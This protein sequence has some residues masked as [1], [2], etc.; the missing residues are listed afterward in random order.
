[1]SYTHFSTDE[2][3]CLAQM[4][5]NGESQAKIARELGKNKSSISREIARNG[6]KDGT[7]QPWWAQSITIHRRRKQRRKILQ[8][9]EMKEYIEEK[10]KKYWSPETISAIWNRENPQRTISF[11]SIYRVLKEKK[12]DGVSVSKNLRRRGKRRYIRGAS[13]T[14]KPDKTI[15]ERPQIIEERGRIGDF[16]G[17][18]MQGAIGKGMLVTQVDRKSRFL[19]AEKALNKRKETIE[20]AIVKGFEGHDVA[21]ITLDNG[22]EFANFREFGRELEADIYFADPHSPWQRGSNENMNG[23]LRF[24]FPKGTDFTQVSDEEIKEVVLLINERPRKCLNW[25]S[26]Q[27]IYSLHF[28]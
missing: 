17:D 8:D 26:P 1:M 9:V 13:S 28:A 7:Y 12:L 15:H 11:V 24:F 21:S 27:Q 16:E 5:R 3:I 22:S 4:L 14:I 23:I 6:K 18:T 19:L 20:K 10:L 2:R 25:M